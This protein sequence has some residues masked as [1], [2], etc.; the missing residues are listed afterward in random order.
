MS[1]PN[2][3][4]MPSDSVWDK[5]LKMGPFDYTYKAWL[6]IL[7][8]VVALYVYVTRYYI[9]APQPDA[10]ATVGNYYYY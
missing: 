8:V 2:S 9:P 4:I 3:Q 10:P 5:Q 7:V 1:N 6:M